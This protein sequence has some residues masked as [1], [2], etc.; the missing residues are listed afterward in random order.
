MKRS[1]LALGVAGLTA[2]G[3]L[4]GCV[5]EPVPAR[6]AVTASAGPFYY[7]GY[8]VSYDAWGYPIFYVGGM[9]HYVPR[10]YPGYRVMVSHY[11]VAPRAAPYR[12][13]R[14]RG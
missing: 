6:V 11:R 3:L 13:R 14:G 2:L 4:N 7:D 9:V 1:L 5:V 10:T 12:Y 8:P